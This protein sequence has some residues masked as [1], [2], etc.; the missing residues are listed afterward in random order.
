MRSDR[1]LFSA[2]FL[3]LGERGNSGMALT[4]CMAFMNDSLFDV[5]AS[6]A[7]LVYY[8]TSL[9]PQLFD[10]SMYYSPHHQ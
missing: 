1:V 3:V 10:R 8:S 9:L 7:H 2:A 4:T 5:I 6:C